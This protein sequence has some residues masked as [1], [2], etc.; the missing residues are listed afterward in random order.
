MLKTGFPSDAA[1]KMTIKWGSLK[2][3]GALGW[4]C[5]N[6]DCFWSWS[7]ISAFK[8]SE[9]QCCS[10]LLSLTLL[11]KN[12]KGTLKHFFLKYFS[13][14]LGINASAPKAESKYIYLFNV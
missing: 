3:H 14:Q 7:R 4:N 10:C 8:P 5:K 13:K 11:W 6:D 12:L 1:L 9:S 2:R